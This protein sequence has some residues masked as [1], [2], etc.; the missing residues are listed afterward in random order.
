MISSRQTNTKRGPLFRTQRFPARFGII[1]LSVS[2]MTLAGCGRADDSPSADPALA[3]SLFAK[4][5]SSPPTLVTS[6]GGTAP[7]AG[8]QDDLTA[9]FAAAGQ[10]ILKL[11]RP[12][13][14]RG[15]KIHAADPAILPGISST[16]A[17]LAVG[18]TGLQITAAASDPWIVLPP[19]VNGRPAILQIE[20][21]VPVDTNMQLFV[22]T[23]ENA[24]YDEKQSQMHP[25]KKGSNTVY[26][27]LPGNAVD[28]IR[29]D[30]GETEGVYV[31]KRAVARPL[32]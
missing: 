13:D 31:L 27:A 3:E 12:R 5:T 18:D 28:P 22:K 1:F 2:A 23:H 26:F 32:Q 30:P 16:N 4:I 20:I 25:V 24:G 21:D 15:I 29:L 7:L 10:T 19:F 17:T 6:Q 14:F 8:S 9:A 11:Q